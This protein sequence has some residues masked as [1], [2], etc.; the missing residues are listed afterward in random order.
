MPSRRLSQ[1]C[2][3]LPDSYD[4]KSPACSNLGAGI[5]TVAVNQSQGMIGRLLSAR[6]DVFHPNFSHFVQADHVVVAE[7]LR[8]QRALATAPDGGI[9]PSTIGNMCH[10]AACVTAVVVPR[11]HGSCT[12]KTLASVPFIARAHGYETL[13]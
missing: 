1:S 7:H 8:R 10:G 4:S 2:H 5:L 11:R 9:V 3:T 13:W 6:V 12:C